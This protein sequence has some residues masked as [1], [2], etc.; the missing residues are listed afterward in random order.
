MH[1]NDVNDL[2]NKSYISITRERGSNIA[3]FN[4]QT[5][6]LL[7]LISRLIELEKINQRYDQKETWKFYERPC[8]CFYLVGS[9]SFLADERDPRY[10]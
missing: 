10:V 2:K 8:L 5:S 7:I 3:K 6:V 4:L 9:L 1:Q